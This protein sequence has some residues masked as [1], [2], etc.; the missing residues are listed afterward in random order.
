MPV[1]CAVSTARRSLAVI[2]GFLYWQFLYT[3]L[4][5]EM[6]RVNGVNTRLINLLLMTMISLVIVINVRMVGFLMITAMTII[7]GAT[8]NMISRRFNGVLISSILIG[9]VGTSAAARLASAN[10]SPFDETAFPTGPV[11]VH[12]LLFAISSPLCLGRPPRHHNPKAIAPATEPAPPRPPAMAPGALRPRP[13][14]LITTPPLSS[15]A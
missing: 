6:A 11:V 2:V 8:A 13:R 1:T 15:P 10:P 3:T 9:T 14:P 4:D 12:L 5:E 7:P